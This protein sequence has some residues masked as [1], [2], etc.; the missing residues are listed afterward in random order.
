[1]MSVRHFVLF[2]ASAYFLFFFFFSSRRRHTRLTCDWSSDVCSSDLAGRL[3]A[4]PGAVRGRA[5]ATR[6][7]LRSLASA[8]VFTQSDNGLF[9]LTPLGETLTSSSPASMRD[10]AIAWM[11]KIGRA[12]CRERG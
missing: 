10:L 6:R 8:G 11:E 3:P 1:M 2:V 7:V 9:G 5:A 4:L 12:S